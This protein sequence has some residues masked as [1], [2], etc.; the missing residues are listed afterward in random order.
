M[1]PPARWLAGSAAISL[2]AAATALLL[3]DQL[4]F[5]TF[6]LE[7]S[8]PGILVGVPEKVRPLP[9]F[10]TLRPA[11]PRPFA[12]VVPDESADSLPMTMFG[13]VRD[14]GRALT[15]V[16]LEVRTDRGLLAVLETDEHGRAQMPAAPGTSVRVWMKRPDF[17]GDELVVSLE[18]GDQI[19]IAPTRSSVRGFVTCMGHLPT[20]PVRVA[21]SIDGRNEP[22]TALTDSS[23]AYEFFGLP[24]SWKGTVS[25]PDELG[26]PRRSR[27][28]ARFG[29]PQML[30]R[31]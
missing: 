19:L 28:K 8:G 23:G 31:S 4:R 14:D 11:A 26:V 27:A 22:L 2:I 1:H 16:V 29:P 10:E 21:L 20:E 15:N 13:V 17:D 3:P 18:V 12:D 5:L 7:S 30:S 9:F 6:R 24:D 25:F